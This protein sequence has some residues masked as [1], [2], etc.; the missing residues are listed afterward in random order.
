MSLCRLA[1][2]WGKFGNAGADRIPI[3]GAPDKN[4]FT[5]LRA[6]KMGVNWVP[7]LGGKKEIPTKFNLKSQP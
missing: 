3:R 4:H 6:G 5:G 1:H 7:Y 2:K